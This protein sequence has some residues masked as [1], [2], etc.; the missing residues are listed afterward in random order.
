M[1]R[2]RSRAGRC[3]LALIALT[4]ASVASAALAPN[5]ERLR[6]FAAIFESPQLFE[7]LGNKVIEG[8]EAQGNGTYRVW[9]SNCSVIVMLVGASG[10]AM[11]GP[12]QFTI[13]V[14]EP[15]CH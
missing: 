13:Q 14:G 4:W 1:S 5:Y 12:W 3:G 6:E 15:Q 10:P 8:I 7:K 9:T 11:P 2:I